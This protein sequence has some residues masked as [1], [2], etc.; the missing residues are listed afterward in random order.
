MTKLLRWAGYGLGTIVVLLLLAA[1]AVWIISS[2]K[3][4]SAV[5]TTQSHLAAP[6]RAQLADAPRQL[7]VLGCA[8]C[9]GA[10]LQGDAFLDDPKLATLYAPNLTLLAARAT[11]QQ[12]DRAIRQGV[13]VDGRALAVMPSQSY[14]FLTDQEAAALIAAVR[15]FPKTGSEQPAR[16]VGPLGRI[17]LVAGKLHTAPS[18]VA[19]YR[20]SPLPDFGRKFAAG[21]HVVQ[22]R[23][24]ECH[25]AD[26][27]GKELE[28]GVV[29][30]DLSMVGAY[31]LEQFRTL[32]RTGVPPSRKKL[33]LMATVAKGDF[34]HLTDEEIEGI[35][36]YLVE[37]AQKAN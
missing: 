37:R 9:H 20:A 10:K 36:A 32:L 35:H 25:G 8:G 31:D 23:C 4:N 1:A 14:Q 3:L 5:S 22:T 26:L 24:S 33:G 11:D 21:R 18:L 17:G 34:S 19:E 6:T 2:R 27:K 7:K 30:T 13:G 28:P 12:L 29:S 16:S 15:H